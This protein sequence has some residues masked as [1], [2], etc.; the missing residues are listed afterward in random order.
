MYR[1]L[2]NLIELDKAPQQTRLGELKLRLQWVFVTVTSEPAAPACW[3]C[4]SSCRRQSRYCWPSR[5]PS[6][7]VSSRN[8][9]RWGGS[10]AQQSS[11]TRYK[12]LGASSGLHSKPLN[13]VTKISFDMKGFR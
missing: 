7:S 3:N 5:S 6:V 4:V 13:L 2:I 10:A 1:S 12:E 8:R 11:I 9:G